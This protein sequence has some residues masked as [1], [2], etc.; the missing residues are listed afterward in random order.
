[1]C[2]KTAVR[3]QKLELRCVVVFHVFSLF[4]YV[5]LPI[6]PTMRLHND[7]EGIAYLNC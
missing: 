1:M 7:G 3:V 6:I 2:L 4:M 5:A